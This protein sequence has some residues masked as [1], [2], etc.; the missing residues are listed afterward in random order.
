M[1]VGTSWL[2]TGVL[3]D[4]ADSQHTYGRDLLGQLFIGGSL[5]LTFEAAQVDYDNGNG[6]DAEDEWEISVESETP[7]NPHEVNPLPGFRFG[8]LLISARPWWSNDEAPPVGTSIPPGLEPKLLLGLSTPGNQSAF[9]GGR[10]TRL[11][12]TI[13]PEPGAAVSLLLAGGAMLRRRRRFRR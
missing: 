9:L 13:V 4:R 11:D 10:A 6:G 5:Y 1:A 3:G 7:D 2:L 8:E 12:V